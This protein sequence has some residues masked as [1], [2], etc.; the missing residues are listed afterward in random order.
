MP[1]RCRQ[2]LTISSLVRGLQVEIAED[3][4]FVRMGFD[5]LDRLHIRPLAERA[6]RMDHRRID[7]GLRHLLQG[8]IHIIGRDLPVLRRHPGVF[9][10][11][12]L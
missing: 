6:G 12:D 4:E 5:R 1:G 9:P 3:A 11:M 2:F 8:V 10:E 7:P